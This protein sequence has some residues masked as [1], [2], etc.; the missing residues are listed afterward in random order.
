MIN[1]FTILGGIFLTVVVFFCLTQGILSLSKLRFDDV[2]F[3][4]KGLVMSVFL[5]VIYL[6]ALVYMQPFIS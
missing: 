5:L 2:W 6:S 1:S 3:W 4:A